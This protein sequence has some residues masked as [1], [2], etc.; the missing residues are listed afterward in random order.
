MRRDAKRKTLDVIICK[1]LSE[2][3]TGCGGETE[4]AYYLDATSCLQNAS[5]QNM[6]LWNA[7]L[8]IVSAVAR[9]SALFD[10]AD[11]ALVSNEKAVATPMTR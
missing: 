6:T 10:S 3:V 8:A 7:F 5:T 2:S 4:L 11:E 9:A 1:I